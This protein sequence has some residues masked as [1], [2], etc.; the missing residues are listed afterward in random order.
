MINRDKV[1]KYNIYLIPILLGILAFLQSDLFPAGS[2]SEQYNQ[3]MG[4]NMISMLILIL[5]TI[6]IFATLPKIN[7]LLKLVNKF[8]KKKWDDKESKVISD[9]IDIY[10]SLL[11]YYGLKISVFI[12]SIVGIIV[13]FRL[14][15]KI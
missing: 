2:S 13:F 12:F 11:V 15:N 6:L 10:C 9:K 8:K 4:L 1:E 7:L 5:V 14:I 3:S